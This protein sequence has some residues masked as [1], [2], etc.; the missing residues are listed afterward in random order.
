M[1][2]GRWFLWAAPLLAVVACCEGRGG[3]TDPPR[4]VF[5]SNRAAAARA[6]D[7]FLLEEQGGVP[8]NLTAGHTK[9]GVTAV[10]APRLVNNR[11]AVLCLTGGGKELSEIDYAT[12]SLRR[13]AG[14]QSQ[15]SR[16]D[17]SPD[18]Q[19]VLLSDLCDGKLQIIQV[20]ILSGAVRNLSR[21]VSNNTEASYSRDGELIA[22]VEDRDGTR[23]IA[24]M[25]R[26]GSGQR[27]LTN[28]FGDDRFPRFSPDGTRIVFS[29]SRSGRTDDQYDLYTIDTT[30][31]QFELLYSNG[32][33]NTT[34]VYSP[35]GKYVA[36]VSSNL[37]MKISHVLLLECNANSAAIVTKDLKGL[38]SGVSFDR[39]GRFLLFE[40]NS[41]SDC[42]VMLYDRKNGSMKN[43]TQNPGWDSSPSF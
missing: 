8:R 32:A 39:D 22:Y 10:A 27:I 2:V 26:D 25:N 9:S 4:I 17:V 3:E 14:L 36:F 42:E 29:S 40:F 31:R 12:G 19:S 38:S 21:N 11:K 30:G 24:L 37:G 20:E 34:P 28:E 16:F 41:M 23:S 5:L 18:G 43:L 1:R 6:F 15:V 33:Y 35:D 7:V 13:I